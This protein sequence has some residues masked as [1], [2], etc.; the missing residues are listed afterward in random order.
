ML[1]TRLF[2]A[3]VFGFVFS[4][5]FSFA[6]HLNVTTFRGARIISFP[7]AGFLP[8]RLAFCFTLNLPKP[9]INTSSPDAR[10]C[11]IS[12]SNVSTVSMDFLRVKPMASATASTMWALVSVPDNGMVGASFHSETPD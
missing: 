11:L 1:F 9:E 6:D 3:F 12:S 10:D 2:F 8:L 7:V 4:F 5:S